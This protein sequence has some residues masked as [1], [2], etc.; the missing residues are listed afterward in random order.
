MAHRSLFVGHRVPGAAAVLG[1]LLALSACAGDGARPET[2]VA[3]VISERDP[4]RLV[5]A[6]LPPLLFDTNPDGS[7]TAEVPDVLFELGSAVLKPEAIELLVHLKPEI[8]AHDGVV[9]VI[10]ETDGLG[11]HDLNEQLSIGRA[12]SVKREIVALV[13]G[14][15]VKASGI[16]ERDAPDNVPNPALRR[17]TI[18][19]EGR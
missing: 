2:Q 10:G 14:V 15:E 4:P 3:A 1:L 8:D 6:S 9:S 7:R 18:H 16:G 5:P 19:L 12:E 17:V 11:S 13:P